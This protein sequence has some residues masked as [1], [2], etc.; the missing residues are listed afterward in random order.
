MNNIC[1]FLRKAVLIVLPC[2]MLLT[3]CAGYKKQTNLGIPQGYLPFNAL[4]DSLALLPPPP[5]EGTS[6]FAL[7]DEI[8]EKS[9]TMRGTGR[10]KLASEDANLMFPH[11]A[12]TFSCA[13]NAPITE[14]DTPH[15]FRLLR[16]VLADAGLATYTA[17]KKYMRIRPFVANKVQSC[18]PDQEPVLKD[19]GSYPSGHAAVV[20]AWALILSEIAPEQTDA[21]IARGRAF[22]QSRVICNVHWQSDV[23]EGRFIGA[24]VVARLHADP[25]FRAELKS[26]KAE[27]AFVRKKGLPPQRDCKAETEALSQYP[28]S[29]PW[30]ADK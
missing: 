23:I 3:A 10:W 13:I 2:I 19:N 1:S 7:D 11:A 17:Q 14:Q 15:L 6:A 22:G 25:E 20:W 27:L 5:A 9:L 24:A 26:A 28:P 4:P 8:S 21:I 16:R 30:P 29:A 18:A 12:G